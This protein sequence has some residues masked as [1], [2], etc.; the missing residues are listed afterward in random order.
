[1]KFRTSS[2]VVLFF[3]FFLPAYPAELPGK[4]VYDKTC[5]NCHGKEG[6]GDK[7]LDNFY[8]VT[9]PRLNSKYVQGKSDAELNKIITAG[10]RKMEP[11]EMGAPTLPHRQKITSEQADE[12]IQYVRT[13][14]K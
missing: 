12:V 2:A 4:A 1:M 6:K 7:M 11:V 14:K 9:I 5:L 8:K 13:L 10:V 3:G